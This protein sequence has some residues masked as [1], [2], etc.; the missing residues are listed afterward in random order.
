M[1][2]SSSPLLRA[3]KSSLSIIGDILR[4]AFLTLDDCVAEDGSIQIDNRALQCFEPYRSPDKKTFAANVMQKFTPEFVLL[5]INRFFEQ[6]VVEGL[7]DNAFTLGFAKFQRLSGVYWKHAKSNDW[8]PFFRHLESFGGNFPIDFKSKSTTY[9][10][11]KV[12][13]S[14]TGGPS[15]FFGSFLTFVFNCVFLN[16]VVKENTTIL[17]KLVK[18]WQQAH[19]SVKRMLPTWEENCVKANNMFLDV[20]ETPHDFVMNLSPEDG[21]A[22]NHSQCTFCIWRNLYSSI[23]EEEYAESQYKLD[24]AKFEIAPLLLPTVMIAAPALLSFTIPEDFDEEEPQGWLMNFD[25][26]YLKILLTPYPIVTTQQ[27]MASVPALQENGPEHEDHPEFDDGD[28]HSV[29]G[30]GSFTST[31]SSAMFT[32]QTTRGSLMGSRMGSVAV[33]DE[34]L[35]N[36]LPKRTR[37][38]NLN[39]HSLK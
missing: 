16:F 21:T 17:M 18:E 39:F 28:N 20:F 33:A 15:Y 32:C 13:M 36:R 12:M 3:F 24:L 9:K 22:W 1:D 25:L 27:N 11:V 31:S 23:W 14:P 26:Y 29:D 5:S 37:R 6:D 34:E 19:D 2:E 35:P 38:G 10:R 30:G 4:E 8:L 7:N